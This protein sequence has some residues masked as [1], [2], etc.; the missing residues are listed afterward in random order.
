LS[1]Q[2]QYLDVEKA[3]KIAFFWVGAVSFRNEMW[4]WRAIDTHTNKAIDFQ[5]EIVLRRAI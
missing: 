2:Y 3:W 5:K 4:D 1:E